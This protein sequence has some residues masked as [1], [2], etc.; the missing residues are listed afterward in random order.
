MGNM[1]DT[2][3]TYSTKRCP[4]ELAHRG[5]IDL[6]IRVDIFSKYAK[7]FSN[8][9]SLVQVSILKAT[10]PV[11]VGRESDCRSK[12]CELDPSPVPFFVEIDYVI[13]STVILLRPLKGCCQ[14][15][16]KVC[17][18]TYFSLPRTI[19]WFGELTISTR[20]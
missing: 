17:A 1:N 10:D 2:L 8:F 5:L 13:Y 7:G 12:G 15:Q 9:S 14:S 4:V 3:T 20:P 6:I 16:A 18:R 11:I 19:V